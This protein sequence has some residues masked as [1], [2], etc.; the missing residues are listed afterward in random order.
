MY[1]PPGYERGSASYPV[2]YLIHGGGDEDSGWSTIGRAGFILDNLIA[3]GKAKPMIVVMPNGAISLPGAAAGRGASTPEELAQ[4]MVTLSRQ[5]DMFVSDLLTGII[6]Y[7]E[8]NYRVLASRT[9]RF[10]YSSRSEGKQ[11]SARPA[12]CVLHAVGFTPTGGR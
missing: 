2:L 1:T 3:A 6:P 10:G 5:H 7:V 12:G 9:S 11:S 4:R 8:Q